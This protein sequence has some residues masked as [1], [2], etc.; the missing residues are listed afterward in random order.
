[1]KLERTHTVKWKLQ[2]DRAAILYVTKSTKSNYQS[3]AKY[4]YQSKQ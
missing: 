2:A 3:R 1:M 4:S